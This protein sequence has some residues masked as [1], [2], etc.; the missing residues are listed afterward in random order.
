MSTD[1]IF[2]GAKKALEQNLD[3][4]KVDMPKSFKFEIMYKEA[5][6]AYRSSFYTGVKK[7]DPKTIE[8]VTDDY[9]EFLRMFMFI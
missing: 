5:K 7:I 4:N 9:Y 1:L 8:F 3:L 6:H 2:K